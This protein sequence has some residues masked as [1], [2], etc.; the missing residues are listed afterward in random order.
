MNWYIRVVS[1][2][3]KRPKTKAFRKLGKNNE[4]NFWNY[5]LVAILPPNMTIFTILAKDSFKVEI[6]MLP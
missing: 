3:G 4:K 6:K 5:N 1:R 2:A